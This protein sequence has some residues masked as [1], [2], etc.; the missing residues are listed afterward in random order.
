MTNTWGLTISQYIVGETFGAQLKMKNP[1][2][3]EGSKGGLGDYVGSFK[4]RV[5]QGGCIFTPKV[6]K[7]REGCLGRVGWWLVAGEQAITQDVKAVTRSGHI[8]S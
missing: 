3:F 7:R 2:P 8:L 4:G 6:D 1:I 5:L